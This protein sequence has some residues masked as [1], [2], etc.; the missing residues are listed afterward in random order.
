MT[1]QQFVISVSPCVCCHQQH[2]Q[3]CSVNVLQQELQSEI[4]SLLLVSMSLCCRERW[5]TTCCNHITLPWRKPHLQSFCPA[6][7]VA[8]SQQDV[9]HCGRRET[10]LHQ[11]DEKKTLNCLPDKNI[12]LPWLTARIFE[13]KFFMLLF[14]TM[15]SSMGSL[16]VWM[17]SSR[18]LE[19]LNFCRAE[20][21]KKNKNTTFTIPAAQ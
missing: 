19:R 5:W 17:L 14:F 6:A 9:K 2:Q 7:G 16:A 20:K 8:E 11:K 18:A 13:W 1:E 12:C 10:L 15:Y 4:M 3:S 21:A